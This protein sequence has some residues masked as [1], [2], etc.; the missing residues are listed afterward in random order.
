[1]LHELVAISYPTSA[2]KHCQPGQ[3]YGT[4]PF[5]PVFNHS[6]GGTIFCVRLTVLSKNCTCKLGF[7][8]AV[9]WKLVKITFAHKENASGRVFSLSTTTLGCP[10]TVTSLSPACHHFCKNC[11][12]L[13]PRFVSLKYGPRVCGCLGA[14]SLV[15]FVV[16]SCT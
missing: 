15:F 6:L 12:Y 9:W 7:F 1:M 16:V 10:C 4:T 14:T 2:C 11:L 5:T 3:L 8:C 13:G